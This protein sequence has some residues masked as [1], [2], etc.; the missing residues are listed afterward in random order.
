MSAIEITAYR[1]SPSFQN[2]IQVIDC[3][4]NL[5][6]ESKVVR[7]KMGGISLELGSRLVCRVKTDRD[8]FIPTKRW[9]RAAERPAPPHAPRLSASIIIAAIRASRVTRTTSILK[10][11]QERL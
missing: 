11:R 8:F 3:V 2:V 7:G 5:T 4:Q 1:N 9:R 10:E 6:K